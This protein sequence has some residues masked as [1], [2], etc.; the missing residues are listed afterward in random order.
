MPET[1]RQS[2]FA[3]RQGWSPSYVTELKKR[4]RLV[5]TPDGLVDVEASLE[6][7][8]QTADDN[9]DDVRARHAKIRN[10]E[11]QPDPEKNDIAS[12]TFQTSRALKERYLAL[13]AKL[14]YET[15]LRTLLKADEVSAAA[16]E[17][18]SILRAQ[19]E[20]LPDL[21]APLLAAE[22]DE[23][24]VHSL[25]VEHIENTLQQIAARL[26]E[27]GQDNSEDRSQ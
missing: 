18:G 17:I 9:R 21:A 26:A 14:E 16:T 24:R 8:R 25:L 19:L 27:I 6:R 20:N 7:I 2:E 10:S 13:T 4:D 5:M 1:V 15:K 23:G 11:P 22:T 12:K 3:R